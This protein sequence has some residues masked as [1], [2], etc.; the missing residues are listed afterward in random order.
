MR[1]FSWVVVTVVAAIAVSR[2]ATAGEAPGSKAGGEKKPAAK[3]GMYFGA[4]GAPGAGVSLGLYGLPGFWMLAQE[5]VQKELE[6]SAEQKEKLL[7]IAKKSQEQS[8][9]D[10]AEVAK[11]PREEQ[12]QAMNELRE[13]TAKRSAEVRKEVEA[14]LLPK[15]LERL[16]EIRFRLQAPAML[17]NPRTLEQL[18]LTDQQKQDLRQLRE[19]L[20]KKMQELQKENTE[21]AL[22]VLSP[23]Q[24][25]KLKEM[26]TP[27]L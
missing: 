26:P 21:K 3:P 18:G 5:N 8:R 25:E 20:Q 2:W 1:R 19:E 7:A 15:Q 9:Q 6:L 17:Q 14:V 10:W 27:G 23:E 16:K 24:I 13:K 4:G 11:L 22:K 12:A